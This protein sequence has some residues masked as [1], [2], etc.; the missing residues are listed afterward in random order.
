MLPNNELVFSA[1]GICDDSETELVKAFISRN[2]KVYTI[3]EN[4]AER[5][6]N[7][8]IP[9]GKHK[10]LSVSAVFS[11]EKKYLEWMLREYN[12]GDKIKLK[13]EIIEILK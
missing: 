9:I 7:E 11:I 10:G 3:Y 2:K 5:E 6:Y 4:V 12:F 1:G 8:L 13:Q